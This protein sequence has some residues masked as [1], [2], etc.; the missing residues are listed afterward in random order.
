MSLKQNN[1]PDSKHRFTR[2]PNKLFLK[3]ITKKQR[4]FPA[5]L[6]D[7]AASEPV[8]GVRKVILFQAHG[9][10]RDDRRPK[11][12]YLSGVDSALL[13]NRR[14]HYGL[15]KFS[16][17]IGGSPYLRTG[18][19]MQVSRSSIRRVK[20]AY[21]V[22]PTPVPAHPDVDLPGDVDVLP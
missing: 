4:N 22:H 9:L 11:A 16:L 6:E 12:H 10:C 2:N 19:L 15:T 14:N 1:L 21:T 17:S 18:N 5:E 7:S 13:Y 20:S 8:F 3:F